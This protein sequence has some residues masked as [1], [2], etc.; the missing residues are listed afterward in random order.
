MKFHM[1]AEDAVE[2]W[3]WK[4]LPSGIW[5]KRTGVQPVGPPKWNYECVVIARRGGAGIP[6]H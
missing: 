4:R 2:A 5:H 1:I 6:H 3:G